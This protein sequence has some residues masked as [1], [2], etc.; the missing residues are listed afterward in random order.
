MI[1]VKE[2]TEQ[3]YGELVE[4]MQRRRAEDKRNRNREE[5]VERRVVLTREA[6]PYHFRQLSIPLM[7]IDD[8]NHEDRRYLE[9]LEKEDK[10]DPSR[11]RRRH[12]GKSTTRRDDSDDEY[13]P[14][15]QR[16]RKVTKDESPVET[17][18]SEIERREREDSDPEEEDEAKRR[19]SES[20]VDSIQESASHVDSEEVTED[21]SRPRGKR[22]YDTD[23]SDEDD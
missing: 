4:E 22:S 12:K 8:P 11:P 2:C 6:G 10:T 3:Q 19:T 7:R 13:T 18:E 1:P 14:P 16:K 9:E 5:A 15:K 20:E 21:E 23:I 17:S